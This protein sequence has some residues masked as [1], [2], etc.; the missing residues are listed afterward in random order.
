MKT[1]R[2]AIKKKLEL[3]VKKYV[4]ERDNYTCQ[5]CGKPVSGTDCHVSH[6]VPVSAGIRFA[7]DPRNCK[8]LCFHDHINWWHKNPT[9]S[10]DWFKKKFPKRWAYLQV[11]KNISMPV[12]TFELVELYETL[13]KELE[14]GNLQDS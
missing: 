12:K 10:G 4:K 6:V 2:Q 1:P 3:L 5:R 13:K 11:R 14:K 8:V 7:F 9:E